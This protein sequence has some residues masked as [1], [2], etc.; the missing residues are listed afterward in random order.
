MKFLKS[1]FFI[2][3]TLAA[4][5]LG[6]FGFFGVF[7]GESGYLSPVKDAFGIVTVATSQAFNAVSDKTQEIAQYFNGYISLKTENET[8]KRELIQKEMEISSLSQLEREN[9]MLRRMVGITKK[10]TPLELHLAHI[11]G[12]EATMLSKSYILDCGTSDGISVGDTVIVNEVLAGV[13]SDVGTT[14]CR[15][16]PV[17]DISVS[18]GATVSKWGEVGICEGDF[19]L[20]SDGLIKLSYLD[21]ETRIREGDKVQTSG[22]GMFPKGFE[23]GT[24]REIRIDENGITAYGVVEPSADFLKI[25]TVFVVKGF[26]Q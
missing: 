16:S 7:W 8:L 19:S 23:I 15:M 3:F 14:W 9:E 13:V 18:V 26:E 11:V 5:I 21:R 20:I 22:G 12:S 17:T 4:L 1:K 25:D 6:G 2:T 10:H 24:V